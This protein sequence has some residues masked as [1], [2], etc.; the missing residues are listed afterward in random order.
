MNQRWTRYLPS[1]LR[2]KV[3]G[4]A[5]LQNVISNT[6]WQFADNILRMGIGLAIGIWVARYLGP[7]QF[8]LFSYALAFVSLFTAFAT[9]GLE[10]I[11]V[12][13]IVHDPS[14]KDETL[15]SAFFLK[16]IG[17]VVCFLAALGTILI[18]RPEDGLNHWL[19]G[20]IAAGVIF[21]SFYVI[22]DWFNSQVQAK[23]VVFARNAAFL[24]CSILK[25]FLIMK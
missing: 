16:L 11:V 10:D 14:C 6:G 8:G 9:L 3:E 13:D 7:E 25:V 1:F 17:G 22:E 5:Y 15:G 21:Q 4:K 24:S 19:V 12:R 2:A 20:I 23:Y 18:L